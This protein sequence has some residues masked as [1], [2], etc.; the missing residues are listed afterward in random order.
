MSYDFAKNQ[1]RKLRLHGEC[2][3]RWKILTSW[4]K[5]LFKG[6]ETC[7]AIRGQHFE[8]FCMTMKQNFCLICSIIKSKEEFLLKENNI[9][10]MSYYGCFE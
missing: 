6:Y 7:G 2:T 5:N 1:N 9:N 3:G 4:S 8:Y 10:T